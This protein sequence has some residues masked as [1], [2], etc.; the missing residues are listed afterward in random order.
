MRH[1]IGNRLVEAEKAVRIDGKVYTYDGP[2]PK[3]MNRE[4]GYKVYYPD[5]YETFMKKEDFEK[6]YHLHEREELAKAAEEQGCEAC[7][8]CCDC[9]GDPTAEPAEN[10]KTDN[11]DCTPPVDSKNDVEIHITG[12]GNE[13]DISVVG[14]GLP[15][16]KALERAFTNS[17]ALTLE[18]AP[19]F[20]K[21][22]LMEG[23]LA[24]L[25]TSMHKAVLGDKKEEET[26]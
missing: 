15:C 24:S 7:E 1:Y 20:M 8:E 16:I 6:I 3:A 26:K 25:K 18:D 17:V 11:E 5:G 14:K 4:E 10:E 19:G 12:K 9:C 13:F 21:V 23:M 22:I 2:I